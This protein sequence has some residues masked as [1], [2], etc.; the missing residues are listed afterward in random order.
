MSSLPSTFHADVL[1]VLTLPLINLIE[2]LRSYLEVGEYT[3]D[4]AVVFFG[5]CVASAG[6]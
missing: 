5:V 6:N 4:L 1:M 2:M 3:F